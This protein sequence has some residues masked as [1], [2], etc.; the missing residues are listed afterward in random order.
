ML[1]EHLSQLNSPYLSLI[2]PK[3]SRKCDQG[4][5]KKLST[6]L[7]SKGQLNLWAKYSDTKKDFANIISFRSYSSLKLKL[8]CS[9]ISPVLIW[10]CWQIPE[11]NGAKQQCPTVDLQYTRLTPHLF[12]W[13]APT[14]HLLQM[15]ILAPPT[16]NGNALDV[17]D[18]LT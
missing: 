4:G 15:L 6:F 11:I 14:R 3:N 7:L 10:S 5:T 13:R 1:V 2:T 9:P 17:D 12:W 16:A 8:A 18:R